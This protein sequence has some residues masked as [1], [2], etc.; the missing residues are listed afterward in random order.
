MKKLLVVL[1]AGLMAVGM[2]VGPVAADDTYSPAFYGQV[3]SDVRPT[4]DPNFVEQS[5]EEF[6]DENPRLYR[7]SGLWAV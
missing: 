4:E 1:L 7:L 6:L 2:A 3:V 5:L